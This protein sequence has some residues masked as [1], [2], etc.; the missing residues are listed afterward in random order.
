MKRV[1]LQGPRQ[2]AFEDVPLRPEDASEGQF[3]AETEFSAVSIGTETA[4]YLGHPPLRPGPIYPRLVGYCNA[5]RVQRVGPGVEGVRA[6]DR[7]L[8]FQAHQSAFIAGSQDVLAVIPASMPAD[9]ASM[10]YLAHLGWRALQQG[11][12]QPG[13]RVAVLGLGV[14]GLATVLVARMLGGKVVALGN[15]EARLSKA[16]E[17]GADVCLRS[18]DP[19][20]A[21]RL[22]EA[23]AGQGIDLVVTTA[24]S[25]EAWRI[26]LELPR[27][28]GR[29]AVVGFPGRVEGPPSWNPLD[30]A[31]FYAKQLT[32]VAVGAAADPVRSPRQDCLKLQEELMALLRAAQ[33]GRLPL[34][35][36][37]THRV[38]WRDLQQV[39]ELA[40]RKDKSLIGAVLDWGR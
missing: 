15:S 1:I 14:I 38:P 16:K 39:Y 31:W 37:V 12:F 10:T 4:A 8:T 29:I 18:D 7:V 22:Q 26:A 2:V 21:A 30:P 6:G 35:R 17:F 3:Y 36:L 19:A 20:L 40:S 28:H 9:T 27:G 5:A 32:I 33:E 23:P 25:W 34:E 11:G 24:N 13:E